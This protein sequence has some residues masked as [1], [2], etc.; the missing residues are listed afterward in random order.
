MHCQLSGVWHSIAYKISE[1]AFIRN[2]F[3]C[4]LLFYSERWRERQTSGGGRGKRAELGRLTGF[5]LSGTCLTNL[6]S[7]Q[8][9]TPR[10]T[11]TFSWCLVP[12]QLSLRECRKVKNISNVPRTHESTSELVPKQE[13]FLP[14]GIFMRVRE[15]RCLIESLME[16]WITSK[17]PLAF[18][19][20]LTYQH[21]TLPLNATLLE[22]Q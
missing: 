5:H 18:L 9:L 15:R 19:R 11:P 16:V 13:T 2:S 1:W 6:N 17:H 7:R 21:S 14:I 8:M 3:T 20:L 10:S 22:N 12:T 4:E